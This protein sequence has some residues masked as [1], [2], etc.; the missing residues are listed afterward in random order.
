MFEGVRNY[1][2]GRMRPLPAFFI[3]ESNWTGRIAMRNCPSEA[4][5]AIGR[6]RRCRTARLRLGQG[7]GVA[8]EQIA[9]LH[10]GS[11]GNVGS[12]RYQRS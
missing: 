4:L 12:A 8:G 2:A 11:I 1:L 6:F 7:H 3:L 5:Q 10:G 9:A